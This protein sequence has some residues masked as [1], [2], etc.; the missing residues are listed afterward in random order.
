MR[1]PTGKTMTVTLLA[2][3]AVPLGGAGSAL[4][5]GGESPAD[6]QDNKQSSHGSSASVPSDAK[7]SGPVAIK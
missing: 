4:A 5:A 1:K 3:G 7:L 2:A 6:T